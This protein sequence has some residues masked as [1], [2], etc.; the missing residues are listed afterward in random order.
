MR[1]TGETPEALGDYL[2][3]CIQA[4]CPLPADRQSIDR[5]VRPRWQ[6]QPAGAVA[7]QQLATEP[8]QQALA[9]TL[10]VTPRAHARL[11][12]VDFTDK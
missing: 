1:T 8:A 12:L 6:P 7:A 2:I 5:K 11:S 10:P 3:A 9:V 4:R